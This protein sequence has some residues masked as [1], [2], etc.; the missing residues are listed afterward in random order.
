MKKLALFLLALFLVSSLLSMAA[1][2]RQN[3]PLTISP[4]PET[5]AYQALPLNIEFFDETP[6]TNM[7]PFHS[8]QNP[9]NLPETTDAQQ[10][11]AT[12]VTT[13]TSETTK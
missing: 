11:T 2:N 12:P 6:Y 10:T 8:Y 7:S 1:C 13:V 9:T 4:P 3:D 5:T